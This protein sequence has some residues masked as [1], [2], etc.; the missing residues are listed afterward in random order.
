MR[1]TLQRP[2]Q[3]PHRLGPSGIFMAA[4][5]RSVA[6]GPRSARPWQGARDAAPRSRAPASPR[7]CR[8]SPANTSM[9]WR[10]WRS[11][12]CFGLGHWEGNLRLLRTSSTSELLVHSRAETLVRRQPS[13]CPHH[14]NSP[15]L[16]HAPIQ[17]KTMNITARIAN[18]RAA[19]ERRATC[20]A[21]GPR[22]LG[23]EALFAGERSAIH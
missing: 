18:G 16:S 17:V 9:K 7:P 10:E 14:S 3:F 2:C 8:A 23:T 20:T 6:G 22:P 13:T 1:F 12:G 15:L 5:K 4:G 21:T 19:S 11:S